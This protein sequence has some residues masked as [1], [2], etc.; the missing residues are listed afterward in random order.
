MIIYNYPAMEDNVTSEYSLETI[1]NWVYPKKKEKVSS[2][3]ILILH[4]GDLHFRSAEDIRKECVSEIGA[5]LSSTS[6]GSVDRIL[7]LVTGDIAFCG[8]Q[9]QYAAFKKFKTML[10]RSLGK[11]VTSTHKWVDIFMVPGNHDIDY[12]GIAGRDHLYYENLLRNPVIDGDEMS[13]RAAYFAYSH[14]YHSIDSARPMICRRVHYFDGFK[15]E[16]NMLNSTFFS[17]KS[18]NDQGLHYF[19]DDVISKL[20]AP[21]GADMAITLMHH[22][23]QWF[24][25]NCKIDLEKAL[26]EKN[27]LIFYGHEHHLA[28]QTITYNGKSPAKILCGGCL[29]DKGNWSDS[30]FFA[31]VYDTDRCELNHYGFKWDDS[32]GIYHKAQVDQCTLPPKR[33]TNL[34]IDYDQKY[35]SGVMKDSFFRIAES[36]EP[37]FVF[38]GL[39]NT[40]P[41]TDTEGVP[42]DIFTLDQFFEKL[43]DKHRIEI[44]G[45][46]S[47]GKSTILKMIFKH[48]LTRKYVLLCRVDDISSKNR[49]RII[50]TL[51][52]TTYGE[53][54]LEYE[55][56]LR[57]DKSEKVILI[58]DIHLIH[59]QHVSDFLTGIEDEFGYIIYTTSNTIKLDIEERIKAAIAQDSYTSYRVLPLN[60]KKRQELV[61]KII[62]LKSPKISDYDRATLLNSLVGILKLQRRYIPLTP[63]VVIYFTDYYISHQ[64]DA[65][66]GDAGIFGKVFEASI[67]NAIAP[68]ASGCLT[69][70]K[71]FAILGKIAF[72]IHENKRYPISHAEIVQVVNQYCEDYGT[73]VSSHEFI[74]IILDAHILRSYDESEL[75]KFGNNNYLAYFVASEIYNNNDED[76]VRKCLEYACFGINSSILMFVTYLA[77]SKRFIDAFLQ[78]L[79]KV[80]ES[81]A[82]FSFDMKEISHLNNM[83][84]DGNEL[85]PPSDEDIALDRAA[86]EEKDRLEIENATVDIINIY[87]YNEDDVV[88]LENQLSCAISLLTLVSRCLPNF[89]HKLRRQE[90]E[91]LIRALYQIPNKIFY[92]W[93]SEVEKCQDMLLRLIREIE[94][95]E[96]TR[97][98]YT[99]DQ[100]KTILQNNSLSLLLE[101]YYVVANSAYREN[102][103]EYLIG[104]ASSLIDFD[105]ETHSLEQLAVLDK[106]KNFSA[107]ITLARKL[108][109]STRNSAAQLATLRMAHHFLIKGIQNPKQADRI[110]SEFFPGAKKPALVY[111]RNISQKKNS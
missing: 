103:Y 15:I 58:D 18:N 72:Y 10:I 67:T 17:L 97:R 74:R 90:K 36:I 99:G 47:S 96:F 64:L 78:A 24:N 49:R 108:K 76:A 42:A 7:L 41:T 26:L 81:W 69:V 66:Q 53:S 57:L 25:E 93:A 101:L 60:L 46:D 88:K 34:P 32:V 86:D 12:S 106:A 70:D 68:Y 50:K 27:T 51:F 87:D 105:A 89:E 71:V 43:E 11:N 55:K 63:Q 29:C 82:E 107:F 95:D 3:K 56:F 80:T 62:L 100:A 94:T 40:A 8:M 35:V 37:Y 77:E 16:V 73:A 19:T 85:L 22:S 92:A 110:K 5:A 28:N 75:Y 52:E 1:Y 13:A 6:I 20:L 39:T 104:T 33:S 111:Q 38:P 23:H 31:C 91:T 59:P 2:M 9:E 98:K 30:E 4:I 44:S 65:A 102:T 79:D 21:T 109:D 54:P 83:V 48:F 14:T 84:L 45:G 61:E